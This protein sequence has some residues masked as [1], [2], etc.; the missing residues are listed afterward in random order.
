VSCGLTRTTVAQKV[1]PSEAELREHALA[2][3]EGVLRKQA[4][5]KLLR[6]NRDRIESELSDLMKAMKIGVSEVEVL[7]A[8]GRRPEDGWRDAVAAKVSE[9]LKEQG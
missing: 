6:E 3:A 7:D 2:L 5:D 1:I 9:R 8:L 4:V